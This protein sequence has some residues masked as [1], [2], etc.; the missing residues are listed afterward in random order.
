MDR[1]HRMVLGT[2]AA[3]VIAAG[4]WGALSGGLDLAGR[5]SAAIAG[6]TISASGTIEGEEVTIAAESA[7]R[8]RELPV[9][10][11]DTIAA[12]TILARLD[13]SLVAAQLRQA[14]AA[15]DVARANLAVVSAGPR[16]E[17]VRA[18]Q[19]ARDQAQAAVEG[20]RAAL[21]N[22]VRLRD[23]PQELIARLDA[24]IPAAAMARARLA[25]MEA[26]GRAED[27]AAAEA[28]VEQA[29]I[30]LDQFR[31]GGR[32][33][34][35]LAA[36]AQAAIART[37]RDQVEAGARDEDLRRVR[38]QMDAA[39]A[40]MQAAQARLA[41]LKSGPR[42]GDLAAAQ[43]AVDQ[44]ETRLAQLREG[45]P[46]AEDVANARLATEAA[47]AALAAAETA[48]S[49]ARTTYDAAVKQR[50]NRPPLLTP[51][52]AQLA[53]A[54]AQQAL[55]QVEAAV[56]QRRIARDQARTALGRLVAG[57]TTWDIR[58]VEESVA[59]ARA[60]VQRLSEINPYDVQV[61]EAQVS[62]AQAALAQA[63]AQLAAAQRPTDF[64]REAARLAV[65]QAEA[66][67][68]RV[69]TASPFDVAA[70][71]AALAQ[72]EATLALRRR[73]FAE[74]DLETQRQA[75][76]QAEAQVRDL[77]TM[78]D[79]P[80][81]AQAQV[82]AARAQLAQADAQLAAA[83]ARL[84]AARAGATAEQLA[85]AE[86]QVRQAE[87]AA[88][89]LEAQLAKMQS[90]AP[91][92]GIVTKRL[93]R[94]GETVAPGAP[95]LTLADLETLTFT[96]YVS[97]RDLGRVKTG[98]AVD[99]SVD[100][101]P[102]ETFHGQVSSIGTRAEFTPRNVQTRQERINLVFAVKVRVDNADGRL[103]PG[104]PVDARI[105]LG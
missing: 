89:V 45:T 70:A 27:I 6:S 103:K 74:Q 80:L 4:A 33:E 47:E 104:M 15:V 61:A 96:L 34:D 13:D 41:Q 2:A 43:A 86:A 40:Q 62:Q 66:Q 51:D 78:R 58:L 8:V 105:R 99:L 9:D 60:G 20:A 21:E 46:R 5:T 22:A 50:D 53:V 16:E 39:H 101:Y 91:R 102:K 93:V 63:E 44:A 30:R 28:T 75:V 32:P 14:R 56:E 24:A 65:T 35:V 73:P 67:R 7:G 36:E 85:V 77:Q 49:D 42:S 71:E 3:A 12:G 64:D 88:G 29:R 72:A 19:A 79:R 55:H 90:A 69:V 26:G 11:G 83:Q 54:Q 59:Q 57:P 23:E 92:K 95:L 31:A 87:A 68:D 25:L 37:R 81:A 18:L 17:D 98:Q 76:A 1:R 82:D 10:E 38:A 94:A 48:V 52:Q 84:D 97:E 100:S